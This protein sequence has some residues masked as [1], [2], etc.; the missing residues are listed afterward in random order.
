VKAA[1]PKLTR[2]GASYGS[3]GQPQARRGCR[4]KISKT[5]PCKVAWQSLAYAIPR[6]HFDTSGKS[7]VLFH[8]RADVAL[9][10]IVGFTRN[11]A[12]S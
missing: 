8:H 4:T 11:A 3:A 12:S 9:G 5:T 1:T 10:L 6:R 2:A 7:P